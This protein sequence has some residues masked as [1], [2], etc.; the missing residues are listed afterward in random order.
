MPAVCEV[1]LPCRGVDAMVGTH[2]KDVQVVG[3]AGNAD[4]RATAR[5][6][7]ERCGETEAARLGEEA[8]VWQA[9]EADGYLPPS[10]CWRKI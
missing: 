2:C 10:A 5:L 1:R 8:K 9:R 6:V 7:G 4:G 3:A